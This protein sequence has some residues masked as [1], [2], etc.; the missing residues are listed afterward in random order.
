MSLVIV[1][2]MGLTTIA[3]VDGSGPL[4]SAEVNVESSILA[5]LTTGQPN[6]EGFLW[7][8]AD[9]KTLLNGTAAPPRLEF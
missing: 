5:A 7:R 2:L 4:P 1:D 8:A 6:E 9:T 3:P